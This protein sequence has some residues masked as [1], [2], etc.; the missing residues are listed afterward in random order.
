[1]KASL[2]TNAFVFAIGLKKP[3]DKIRLSSSG[4]GPMHFEDFIQFPDNIQFKEFKLQI[5]KM[6]LIIHL[7][8]Y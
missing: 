8:S 6:I 3:N 7:E 4:P 2:K 1:M 5:M